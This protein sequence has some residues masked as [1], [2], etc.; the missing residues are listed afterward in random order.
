MFLSTQTPASWILT[1]VCVPRKLPTLAFFRSL[2]PL[3]ASFSP[4]GFECTP[5]RASPGAT[6]C[7][8]GSCRRKMWC[9]VGIPEIM[10]SSPITSWQM[11]KQWKQ[12]Q[13]LFSWAPKSLQMVTAAM[14]LKDACSL[15]EN[16]DQP[17]QHIKKQRYYFADKRP[18]SQNNDFSSSRVWMWGLDHQE[19]WVLKNW[20]FWTVVLEKRLLRVPW[21]ARRSHQSIQKEISPEYSLEGPM[22][23]LQY[24]GHLLWWYEELT[25]WKRPWC[26][27]RLKAGGE[28]DDRGWD[29]WMAS[30][31]R[32]TQVWASSGSWWW[33]GKP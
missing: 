1:H 17:R 24:F 9:L 23:K 27:E 29:G 18:Y 22:L 2:L 6:S 3:A 11:G 31:T 4:P 32:R 21:T 25:Y 12:W 26:R 13:T 15:E 16:N 5:I 10:S 7:S 14:K 28:G 30:P 20:C 19:S 8:H 33:T